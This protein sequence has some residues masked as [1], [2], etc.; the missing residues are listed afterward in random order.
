MTHERARGSRSGRS[1]SG[2]G[3]PRSGKR[4]SSPQRIEQLLCRPRQAPRIAHAEHELAVGPRLGDAD[5]AERQG[6]GAAGAPSLPARCR[7]RPAQPPGGRPRRSRSHCTRTCMASARAGPHGRRDAG[8]GRCPALEPDKVPVDDVDAARRGGARP[9][10]RR[11]R[12]GRSSRGDRCR[13]GN[14]SK[15][16]AGARS[17][18]WRCRYRRCRPRWRPG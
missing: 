18:I 5:D 6:R 11:A 13:N 17:V 16:A 15:L 4:S 9:A 10:H 7:C 14:R 12:P 8:A 2:P 1:M 3:G